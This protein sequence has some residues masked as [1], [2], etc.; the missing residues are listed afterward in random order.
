M[1]DDNVKMPELEPVDFGNEFYIMDTETASLKGGL[2]EFA[3]LKIDSDLKVLDEFCIR[4][5][6]GRPIDPGAS[7]V[8][9]ITDDDVKDCPTQE[10]AVPKFAKPVNFIAHNARFDRKILGDSVPIEYALCSLATARTY[11]KNTTNHK[12]ETLQRELGLPPMKS[13]TALG[14]VHTVRDLLEFI[15]NL[16]GNNL[17]TLF[18]RA[19]EARMVHFMPFG[20]HRGKPMFRVPKEYRLWLADQPDLDDD[21]KFT[22]ERLNKV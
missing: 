8:H 11:I 3:Y 19:Q 2:V 1:E 9:G 20:K 17:Q 16:S 10:E 15:V 13:H 5:N 6:P 12:L 4:V 7:M 21:L 22:L 14:D 18:M